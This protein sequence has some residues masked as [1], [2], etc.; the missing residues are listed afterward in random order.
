MHISEKDNLCVLT[1]EYGELSSEIKSRK[2]KC[3]HKYFQQRMRYCCAQNGYSVC[4]YIGKC[5]CCT[6]RV[7]GAL[8]HVFSFKHSLT[9][10]FRFSRSSLKNGCIKTM[11]LLFVTPRLNSINLVPMSKCPLIRMSAINRLHSCN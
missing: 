3:R 11:W 9:C 4:C 2:T 6:T 7:L 10:V 1:Y 8:E 5:I